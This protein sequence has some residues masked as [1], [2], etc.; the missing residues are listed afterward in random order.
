MIESL[1]KRYRER[2]KLFLTLDITFRIATLYF[3][4]Q[5]IFY[6]V[7]GL[8]S[9]NPSSYSSEF[10][11]IGMLFSLGLMNAVNVV[12]MIVSGKRK[13]LTS[14]VIS[15]IFVFG[16]AIFIWFLSYIK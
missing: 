12:E 14:L 1:K 6:S 10:L 3:A 11:T 5:L 15:T 2:N 8:I 16:V 13:Y 4:V 9:S 7:S